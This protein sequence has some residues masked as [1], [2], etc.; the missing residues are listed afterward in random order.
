[1]LEPVETVRA[2]V[3]EGEGHVLYHPCHVL[4][5]VIAL[6]LSHG[7]CATIL[8]KRGRITVELTIFLNELRI[9]IEC[10]LCIDSVVGTRAEV[11]QLKVEKDVDSTVT[12]AITAVVS[13]AL[14][15]TATVSR[16]SEGMPICFHKIEL[17]AVVTTG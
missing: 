17:G 10:F 14:R 2:I 5:I 12:G 7:N 15:Q 4:Q 6:A 1:M 9:N 8:G 13:S 11:I 3:L 16:A